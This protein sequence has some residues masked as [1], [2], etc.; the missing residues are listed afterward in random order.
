MNEY[1]ITIKPPLMQRER[2]IPKPTPCS[3]TGVH[4]QIGLASK[5]T[6][7]HV[8]KKCI[9]RITSNEVNLMDTVQSLEIG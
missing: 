3:C 8:C 2:G 4:S 5:K 9:F 6:C 1:V 7:M